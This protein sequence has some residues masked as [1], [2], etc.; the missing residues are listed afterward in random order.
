M[1]SGTTISQVFHFIDSR[2]YGK[3]SLEDV[4]EFT[5]TIPD[6]PTYEQV[7][8]IYRQFD[9]DDSNDIDH[10]EFIAFCAALQKLTRKTRVTMVESFTKSQYKKL[11]V[12]ADEDGGGTIDLEEMKKLV[13]TLQK[14]LGLSKGLQLSRP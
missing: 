8:D 7:R 12:M 4:M 14:I 5:E 3:L 13:D 9:A 1:T 6:P 11:F 2:G 10:D